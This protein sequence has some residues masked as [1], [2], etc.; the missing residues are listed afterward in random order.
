MILDDLQIL[1]LKGNTFSK[2]GSITISENKIVSV[3]YN[4]KKRALKYAVP[5]FIDL[6][7]HGAIG[8]EFITSNTE[9]MV[10]IAEYEALNGI[11][12]IIPASLTLSDKTL[13]DGFNNAKTLLKPQS[14]RQA[15]FFGINL[16]GPFVS[17]EKLGAQNAK[18]VKE[19]SAKF[20]KDLN[21]ICPIKI[22]DLAPEL[23]N[24]IKTINELKNDFRISIAHTNANYSTAMN[25]FNTGARHVT[26]LFNAMPPFLHREPSVVGSAFD[27][28][29][30]NKNEFITPEIITDGVHLHGSIVRAVFRLFNNPII[31]SDSMKATGSFKD[32]G[33]EH[34]SEIGGQEVIIKKNVARLK[35]TNAIAGSVT[36]LFDCFR[37]AVIDMQ[38]DIISALKSV[39]LAPAKALNIYDFCGEI[40][41]NKSADILILDDNL[42]IEKIFL[43]GVQ[44]A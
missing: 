38:V 31:V 43:R 32:D 6:H 10:S 3:K 2:N 19:P 42:N 27:F 11:T 17:K 8:K 30:M 4:N 40:D 25:A 39:T 37:T 12:S 22:V 1:D 35:T 9:D 24:S 41:F 29:E 13:F 33:K 26:H 44:I 34:I 14:M 36:S 18:F 16:E 7:F 21:D 15:N 20:V 5:G 23:N 28:Q